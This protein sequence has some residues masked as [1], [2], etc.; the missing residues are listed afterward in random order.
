VG[1]GNTASAHT[2]SLFFCD[3]IQPRAFVDYKET[4]VRRKVVLS[5]LAV[6]FVL[7]AVAFVI[8]YKLAREIQTNFSEYPTVAQAQSALMK[9]PNDPTAHRTLGFYYFR[10]HN[11]PGAVSEWEKVVL[12]QPQNRSAKSF[13]AAALLQ[14][15]QSQKQRAILLL[16]E[17]SQQ[18]DPYGRGAK[19]AL[20]RLQ[21]RQANT[22]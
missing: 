6:A 15:S 17:L 21:R 10:K 7:L 12:E 8:N 2:P 5:V 3:K 9:D 1:G 13:L 14:G 4:G 20:S 19:T 16:T 11:I 18:D 22:P